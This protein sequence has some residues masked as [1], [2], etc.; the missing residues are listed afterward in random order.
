MAA[1]DYCTAAELKA[2]LK[3]EDTV[4]D[5]ILGVAITAASLQID[6]HCGRRFWIDSTVTIREMYAHDP[7]CLD[8]MEQ[9]GDGPKV[10]IA[11]LT[12]LVVKTDS[13]GDGTFETTLTINTDFIPMPR[14]AVADGFGFSELIALDAA[15]FPCAG[16]RPGVQ[17]T[18]KFG[19]PSVPADVK[20]AC[21]VQ[22]A[23]LFKTKDAVFG[24]AALGESGAMFLKAALN[25]TAR[26]LLARYQ[27]P[28]VG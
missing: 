14:N 2:E 21:L 19:F 20:K 5:T 26:A 3:I 6:G 27:R 18:A 22:A 25:P 8:L 16:R 24:A 10:D 13:D 17:V 4:D 7:Y 1:N 28:P 15:S 9:P 23:Q 11:T 12:G